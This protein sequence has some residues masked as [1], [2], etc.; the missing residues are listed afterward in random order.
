MPTTRLAHV[1]IDDNRLATDISVL[2]K[3]RFTDAYAEFAFGLWRTLMIRNCDGTD[4]DAV[5]RLYDRPAI[6]TPVGHTLPYLRQLID[7][8]FDVSRLRYARI[9]KIERNAGIIP[10]RDYLEFAEPYVRLHLPI[11]T[12][13]NCMNSE[14]GQVIHLRAGEVW[15]LDAAQIHSAVSFSKKARMHL[16]MDFA[17]GVSPTS[18]VRNCAVAMGNPSPISRPKM[19]AIV[20]E[21]INSFGHV[22]DESNLMDVISIFC[23]L[24]FK[25]QSEP[26]C[27]FDWLAD[28]VRV[29]G[30]T[31][32]Q[33]RIEFLEL[34]CIRARSGG[35]LSEKATSV[36]LAS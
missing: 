25:Y 19:P 29:G 11:Q 17:G 31:A 9:M 8:Y 10:H 33:K 21:A 24:H 35:R 4:E 13:D 34:E 36:S 6:E 28:I 18:L 30:N 14:G 27:V 1:P 26:E 16:V 7:D 20:R 23:K 2:S 3:A 12:D 15:Y 22:L 5:I 32:L